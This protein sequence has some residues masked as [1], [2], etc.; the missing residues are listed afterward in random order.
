MLI[1]DLPDDHRGDD[2]D[3]HCH[4]IIHYGVRVLST[5]PGTF[6]RPVIR[7]PRV[8]SRPLPFSSWEG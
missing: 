1:A 8:V 6:T 2:S 4:I 7:L 5:V 3:G